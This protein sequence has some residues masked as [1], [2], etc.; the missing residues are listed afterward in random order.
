MTDV[1]DVRRVQNVDLAMFLPSD[2]LTKVDIAGM[3]FGLEARPPILDAKVFEAASRISRDRLYSIDESGAYQGKLPLKRLL[4]KHL[5]AKFAQR[6]KQGFTLPLR[7]W[8]YD[9][10]ATRAEV[11]DR[12]SPSSPITRWFDPHAISRVIER[13]NP[14]NTWLLLTLD[15]WMRQQAAVSS[16]QAAGSR[17]Q[18]GRP[19]HD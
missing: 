2:I 14:E 13:G 7:S 8:L 12:L 5:G 16:Q 4:A 9:H 17:Q 18:A 11:R 10:P 6:P 1:D 15:E 3:A 19:L